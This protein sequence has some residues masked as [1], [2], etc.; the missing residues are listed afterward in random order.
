MK[1]ILKELRETFVCLKN[2]RLSELYKTEKKI[3][4]WFSRFFGI[5]S[6]ESAKRNLQ[7]N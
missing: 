3:M 4:N 1:V 2:I 5:Q 6:I 7:T